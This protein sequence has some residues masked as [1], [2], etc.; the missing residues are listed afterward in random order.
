MFP[1]T[2]NLKKRIIR[3]KER[4]DHSCRAEICDLGNATSSNTHSSSVRGLNS[5]GSSGYC[6]NTKTGRSNQGRIFWPFRIIEQLMIQ[7]T[8]FCS[9]RCDLIDVTP[10]HFLPSCKLDKGHSH[11]CEFYANK[12]GKSATTNNTFSARG[13]HEAKRNRLVLV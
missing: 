1:T 3:L 9:S 10:R 12:T 5:A 8:A 13:K 4:I 2:H 6:Y 7:E 11:L